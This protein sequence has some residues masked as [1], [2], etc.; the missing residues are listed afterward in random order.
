MQ[1][2]VPVAAGL[3][4]PD[5]R[6][7]NQFLRITPQGEMKLKVGR[8]ALNKCKKFGSRCIDNVENEKCQQTTYIPRANDIVKSITDV[9]IETFGEENVKPFCDLL[10]NN[11]GCFVHYAV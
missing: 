4:W 11:V 10:Y 3:I 9:L 2:R 5:F 6:E 1:F 7:R 8:P